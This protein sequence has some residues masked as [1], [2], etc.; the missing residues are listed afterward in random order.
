MTLHYDAVISWGGYLI[1]IK[2][3]VRVQRAHASGSA[4][5]VRR[6]VYSRCSRVASGSFQPFDAIRAKSFA[7]QQLMSQVVMPCI[8]WKITISCPMQQGLAV[9][10]KLIALGGLLCTNYPLP[11]ILVVSFCVLF[12]SVGSLFR[13]SWG[14]NLSQRIPK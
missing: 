13:G 1:R 4:T 2:V 14:K 11:C 7:V 9:H 8:Q 5:A 10:K 12:I 6:L 3:E